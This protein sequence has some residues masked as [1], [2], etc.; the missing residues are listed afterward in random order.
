MQLFSHRGFLQGTIGLVAL[1]LLLGLGGCTLTQAINKT[2]AVEMYDY[3]FDPP[4][5]FLQ[6]GD[7]VI[8]VL[9]EDVT[10]AG[11]SATTYHP[12]QD[13]ELRIPQ[14]ATVWNSGLLHLS[15]E[16]FE[17]R[18]DVPGVYDYFCIPHE[19]DGMVGRLIVKEASGPG[20]KPLSE[21]VSPAAQSAMPALEELMGPTGH[22]FNLQAEINYVVLRVRQGNNSSALNLLDQLVKDLQSRLDKAG[23]LFKRLKQLGFESPLQSSFGE[24]RS[25][26]V[27]E[28]PLWAVSDKAQELKR[29]LNEVA[30]KLR[31]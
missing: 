23:G 22:I 5:L 21:G 6:P 12:T 20:S 17:Q 4:G 11:H 24:L 2:Y 29:L 8:W 25:L 7:R 15:D 28:A 18:F 19:T 16:T 27:S 14:N 10:T 3:Y 1:L 31:E 9:V 30:R 26:I 13:K